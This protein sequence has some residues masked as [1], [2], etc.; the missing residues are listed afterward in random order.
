M[1][2]RRGL[3]DRLVKPAEF[4]VPVKKLAQVGREREGLLAQTIEVAGRG[5][6]ITLASLRAVV[7]DTT[8]QLKAIAHPHASC[9]ATGRLRIRR[10]VAANTAFARAG[11]A[12]EVP[13]SPTPPGGSVLCTM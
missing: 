5:A 12:A 9:V 11:I 4:D 8:V 1:D 7:R 13:G 2:C 10:P 3:D 6:L